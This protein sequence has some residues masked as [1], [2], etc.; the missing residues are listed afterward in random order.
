[1][2][3]ETMNITKHYVQKP[4]TIV[5]VVISATDWMH[6]MNNDSL[7]GHLAEWLEETRRT[8]DVEV[9]GVITKLDMVQTLSKNSPI[10]KVLTGQLG[11]NHVLQG[12]RV[13]RWIP[14][15][16]SPE[17]RKEQ[18]LKTAARKE[19]DAIMNVLKHSIPS[20]LLAEM[21]IGRKALLKELKI[22]L[23]KA[24]MKTQGGLQERIGKFYLI[25]Q[26]NSPNFPELPPL[27]KKGKLLTFV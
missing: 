18:N 5:L 4:N 23:L 13:R 8:Q 11:E 10:R 9:Y 6:G 16:S 12:L 3:T 1:M 2:Q 20:R 19:N 7:C 17:I 26:Q 14:V 24:I 22:A 21:S 15:V 25:L 27:L